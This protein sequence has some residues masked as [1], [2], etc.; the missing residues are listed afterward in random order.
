MRSIFVL[1]ASF[2]VAQFAHAQSEDAQDSPPIDVALVL[3]TVE[4]SGLRPVPTGAVT[5]AVTVL[6]AEALDIRNAPYLADELRQVPG[7]A[8]SRSGNVGGLTQVRIRGA[9][10]N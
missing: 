10:A 4:V 7:L 2:T 6:D 8:V 3:D 5:G 9:E 1:A